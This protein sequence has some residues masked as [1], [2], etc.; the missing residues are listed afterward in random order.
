MIRN[1]RSDIPILRYQERIV[2]GEKAMLTGG[3]QS[4]ELE[5]N[6]IRSGS[7]VHLPSHFLIPLHP[8]RD[9]QPVIALEGPHKGKAFKTMKRSDSPTLFDISPIAAR[10]R[11]ALTSLERSKLVVFDKL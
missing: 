9:N 5:L 8:T 6:V 10:K 4:D 7:T 1:T 2:Q 3:R 11:K